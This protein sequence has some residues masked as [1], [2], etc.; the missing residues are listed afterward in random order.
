MIII[1][2]LICVLIPLG[3]KKVDYKNNVVRKIELI[4]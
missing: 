3:E 4:K 2:T 1:P